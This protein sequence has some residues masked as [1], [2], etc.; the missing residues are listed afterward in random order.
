MKAFFLHYEAAP[1][2]P[3]AEVQGGYVDVCSL[4]ES[5]PEAELMAQSLL[6][7][8]RWLAGELKAVRPVSLEQ[9]ADLDTLELT[10]LAK[11][12][13]RT[14]PVALSIVAWG[15]PRDEPLATE[16]PIPDE[17]RAAH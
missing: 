6:M 10:L 14:P 8:H 9:P 4:C 3:T 1:A 13:Q 2:A 11:A 5:Q 12:R 15:T 17:G 16:L 7:S